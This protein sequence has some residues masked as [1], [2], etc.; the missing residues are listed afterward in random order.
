MFY[1]DHKIGLT[2]SYQSHLISESFR[3]EFEGV[4]EKV[5]YTNARYQIELS[6]GCYNLDN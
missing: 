6:K 2:K 1:T 5:P 3:F 4:I